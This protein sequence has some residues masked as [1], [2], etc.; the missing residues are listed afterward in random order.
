MSEKEE[1]TLV[2]PVTC[3]LISFA[4]TTYLYRTWIS[5]QIRAWKRCTRH[6]SRR[7]KRL[8]RHWAQQLHHITSNWL[9]ETAAR[10]YNILEPS[11]WGSDTSSN[12]PSNLDVAFD[13][14]TSTAT[15]EP[16]S[17]PLSLSLP[18]RPAWIRDS[19][20]QYILNRTPEPLPR[21]QWEI[22]LEERIRN[23]R[24]PSAWLDR[25]V[26][27]VVRQV[28]A[29]FDADMRAEIDRSRGDR[30]GMVQM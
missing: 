14:D 21:A 5:Q 3:M 26:D 8:I 18:F 9:G 22:E 4:F 16:P 7:T 6:I 13:S 2:F 30:R 10:T 19:N 20:G 23:G 15:S 24:G 25:T 28:V 17:P 1:A 11:P 29:D 27:W 12:S